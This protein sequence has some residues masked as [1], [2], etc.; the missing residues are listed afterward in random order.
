MFGKIKIKK[1]G[2]ETVLRLIV[3]FANQFIL[4]SLQFVVLILAGIE[5]F[6]R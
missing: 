2:I 4:L 1:R 3:C 5:V 6:Y